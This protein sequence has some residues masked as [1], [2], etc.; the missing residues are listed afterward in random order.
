MLSVMD[1]GVG[2]S[3]NTMNA[4]LGDGMSVKSNHGGG[5]HGYGH[6]TVLPSSDL[7]LV[8]YGGIK[9][10][11]KRI[12][13]GH[14]ILA[15]FEDEEGVNKRKDGYLVEE[16]KNDFI[17]PYTFLFDDD[18]P[19]LI[20]DKINMIVSEWAFGT[21]VIVP[22]FNF[23]KSDPKDIQ[24][25]FERAVA[26]NFFACFVNK[27]IIVEFEHDDKKLKIDHTNIEDV[28]KKFS[29]ESTSRS[30]IPG[31]KAF[32]CYEVIKSGEDVK[33]HTCVG[34]ISGKLSRN[35]K[36]TR[37]DLCRNGMWIVYNNS[38]IKQLPK[39]KNS[40]FSEYKPFHL[41]LLLKATDDKLHQLIRRAEPPIHDQ[42]D[43]QALT[44]DDRG[45][46]VQAFSEIQAQIKDKIEKI[47]SKPISID[48]ILTIPISGESPGGKYG[49]YAGEWEPF[50]REGN[51]SFG[52]EETTV[53]KEGPGDTRAHGDGDKPKK[54]SPGGNIPTGQGKK[55]AKRS[56]NIIPFAGTAVP[57]GARR[58]EFEISPLEYIATGEIRFMV[59]E[60]MDETC[61]T[62]HGEPLVYLK[63]VKLNK[64]NVTGDG[65]NRDDN[66]NAISIYLSDIEKNKRFHLAF[67]F[68]ISSD[69]ALPETDFVGLKAEILKC[70]KR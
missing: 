20:S 42:V 6:L 41:V 14:C 23:F 59:N 53:G 27:D 55:P 18:I 2:L 8:Y 16:L 66:G 52:S 39:L 4:L 44:E 29:D 69:L 3:E 70:K 34:T 58:Y 56:G 46:L 64:Q 48:G 57:D 49:K 61:Q 32:E 13:S 30:F 19:K 1:N 31:K 17:T 38:A 24:D 43:I 26:T 60:N 11:E 5:A 12:A 28:L 25:S 10:N 35:A 21:V 54:K 63:N 22:S 68:I 47:S 65:L 37:I 50:V 45:Q 40:A 7:R 36:T 51:Y 15:P 67:D 9:E 62:M 33:F